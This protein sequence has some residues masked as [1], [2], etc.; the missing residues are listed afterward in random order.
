MDI[1]KL[2]KLIVLHEGERLRMYKCPA[3]K[4]TIGV[5]HNIEDRG[6]SKAV[7]DLMFQEDVASSIH[8]ASQFSWFDELS[9]ARQIVIVS[10]IFNM[11]LGTFKEFKNTIGYIDAGDYASAAGEM[12]DS[13]WARKVGHRAIEL[14]QMMEEG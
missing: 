1:S 9:E 3:G 12:L 11:G 10:M 7:S 8:E 13:K 14:S 4:W 5:G 6:I 2:K